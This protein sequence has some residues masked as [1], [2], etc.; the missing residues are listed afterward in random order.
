MR[1]AAAVER[2]LGSGADIIG[3][4]ICD[5]FFLALLVAT[6]TMGHLLTFVRPEESPEDP[7]AVLQ[8]P[9]VPGRVTSG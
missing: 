9:Q 8:P 5:E 1:N 6:H 2:L 4:T 3:K 7:P